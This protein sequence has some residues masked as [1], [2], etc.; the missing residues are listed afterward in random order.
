MIS[1]K[2]VSRDAFQR[3]LKYSQKTFG[4]RE[5]YVVNRHGRIRV[6]YLLPVIA[7]PMMIIGTYGVSAL[8]TAGSSV[9]SSDDVDVVS[10]SDDDF[11]L[12]ALPED[13]RPQTT[14][15]S[16]SVK[17]FMKATTKPKVKPEPKLE[18]KEDILTIAKGGTLSGALSKAGFSASESYKIV[19]ALKK[20]YDPRDLR[21]GQK[22]HM[23]YK[24]FG[25]MHKFDEMIIYK[26]PIEYVSLSPNERGGF[27]AKEKKR[28]VTRQLYARSA[29]IQTSLYG[30]AAKYGIPD[31]VIAELIH[32]YSWDVDFQRD[33]RSGDIIEVFY[34]QIETK[35]G[36][37]VAN[38][39]IL[40]ARLIS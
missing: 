16:P 17:H 1:L 24:P 34:E 5:R 2:K 40:Y 27:S 37:K 15:K 30:S 11:M 33:I 29:Q 3:L 22:I 4:V 6:R 9:F 31:S 25:D 14:V 28:D 38:G 7:L 12:S 35:E 23:H 13:V 18:A 39:D 20:A 36:V 21:A 26:N 8:V 32:M 19:E 10:L